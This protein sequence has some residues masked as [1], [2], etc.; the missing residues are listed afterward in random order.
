MEPGGLA[1]TQMIRSI[2]AVIVLAALAQGLGSCSTAQKHGEQR[3]NR[4][5]HLEAGHAAQNPLPQATAMGLGAVPI[6]AFDDEEVQQA[7]G[8][9]AD[10]QPLYLMPV[11]HPKSP[12]W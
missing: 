5:V 7:L 2:G 9:L 11:G 12:D 10:N 6:G 1:V 3:G 4:H 8:R